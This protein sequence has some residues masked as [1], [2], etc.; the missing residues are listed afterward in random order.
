MRSS[1]ECQ[2]QPRSLAT[3]WSRL[4]EC[5]PPIDISAQFL[6]D[7]PN[8]PRTHHAMITAA[9]SMCEQDE[10]IGEA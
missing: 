4:P 7:V 2:L 10:T 5:E 1:K 3:L 8:I 6:A 9:V